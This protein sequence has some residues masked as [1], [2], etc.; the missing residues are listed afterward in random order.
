MRHAAVTRARRLAP[1]L[2]FVTSDPATVSPCDKP[3]RRLARAVSGFGR[4]FDSGLD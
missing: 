2:I 3:D 1:R 4:T